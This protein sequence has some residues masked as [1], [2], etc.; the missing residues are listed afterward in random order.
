MKSKLSFGPESIYELKLK[1]DSITN[2]IRI[3]TFRQSGNQTLYY[4]PTKGY[5]SNC[6]P[7][8][9]LRTNSQNQKVTLKGR[10][11][12][13]DVIYMTA[14]HMCGSH[15]TNRWFDRF[16]TTMSLGPFKMTFTQVYITCP[17]F[18]GIYCQCEKV[19]SK[20]FTFT[21]RQTITSTHIWNPYHYLIILH[22]YTASLSRNLLFPKEAFS[23]LLLHSSRTKTEVA[24]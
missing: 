4:N 13:R 3:E 10:K 5:P 8:R 23:L 2:F 20:A 18:P 19:K 7:W 11:R 16:C 15:H 21:N 14:H 9:H 24:F 12:R 6:G 17:P 22:H 1:I